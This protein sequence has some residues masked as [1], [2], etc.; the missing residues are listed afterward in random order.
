[1]VVRRTATED[2]VVAVEDGGGAFHAG[3]AETVLRGGIGGVEVEAALRAADS[4]RA[5]DLLGTGAGGLGHG[6]ARRLLDVHLAS[7]VDGHP[8]EDDPPAAW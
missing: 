7:E 5:P 3:G 8:D 6:A 1:V 2:H 4:G